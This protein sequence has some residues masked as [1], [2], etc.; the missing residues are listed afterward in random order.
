MS[1]E[2]LLTTERQRREAAEAEVLRLQAQL[3]TMSKV[4]NQPDS[5]PALPPP[6]QQMLVG[7]VIDN[8]PN[9]IY[10]E[11]EAGNCLLSNERYRQL[12][13]QVPYRVEPVAS[14]DAPVSFEESYQLPDG[15]TVWYY[16]TKTP[17]LQSD[18]SRCLVTF[19]SEITDLKSANRL[20][21]EAVQARQV[22]MASMSHELRTPLHGIMGLA[23]LL[24]K[25]PLSDEQADYAE[26]I[27]TSTENLLVV[28]N[29]ILDFIKLQSGHISL[30]HIPFDLH[31]T[32]R[33][34][35]RS[36]AFKMDEKGLLLRYV[37]FDHPLPMAQGD[38]YRLRQV[39]VNL[40][41]NAIKFTQ[42][43][44]I[45]ITIDASQQNGRDLP[46]T[47]SVADTGIGIDEAYLGQVFESFKQADSSI[48][49][50]YGGTGLGLT[51]CKNLVELQK[52]SIGVR[53]R[54]GSGTCFCFTIPYKVSE[55]PLRQEEMVIQ[56]PDL[57]Q[58]LTILLA[59]DNAVNQ[60]IAVAMLGQWQA[61]VDVAQNGADALNK[62]SRT[63]YDLILMDVQ[64]PQFDGLEATARLRSE[65]G[66]N[67]H[68][69]IVALTADA[70][71]VDAGSYQALGFTDYLTKP[72]NE[73]A[74]YNILAHVSRRAPQLAMQELG[75]A[76]PNSGLYYDLK[77]FGRLADDHDFVGKLLEIFVN[78]VPAQVQ[79][80]QE[81][82]DHR[83][84]SAMVREAH[85]LK[86]TF[87]NFNIQPEVDHL[88]LIEQMV[89]KQA[90]RS[91][92]QPL[93]N[94]VATSTDLFCD[95]FRQR[96]MLLPQPQ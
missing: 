83:N 10:V 9:L 2:I 23:E 69:P 76:S 3:A 85:H 49:R 4:A 28:I 44:T 93:I 8:S 36:L 25:S 84:W 41:S 55:E 26:M 37:G 78:T 81:A 45:T 87:G 95:I 82:T 43:G 65:P 29:D 17:L 73:A 50:L 88:R 70:V 15:Q 89:E 59:E 91:E 71:K 14:F 51:I 74:L 34:A 53:S 5:A 77:M 39:L 64:M 22:F 19:A 27:Q 62:A 42:R 52:G 33:D 79:A 18:G 96:L 92:F 31:K 40:L 54:L 61:K 11:D 68:T 94:A 30:E 16:T 86:T 80:L 46:V 1:L 32:V 67:Q 12:N 21:E 63:K 47:L 6:G 13:Q 24:R 66:L 7:Q 75:L 48:P 57:L 90:S 72:Y 38:P 58:G 60:L 20:A 56:Q 35:V